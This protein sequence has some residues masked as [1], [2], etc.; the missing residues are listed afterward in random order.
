[1]RNRIHCESNAHVI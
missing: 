1:M